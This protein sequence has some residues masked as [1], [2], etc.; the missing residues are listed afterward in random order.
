MRGACNTGSSRGF[1]G[2]PRGSSKLKKSR[3]EVRIRLSTAAWPRSSVKS[4]VPTDLRSESMNA[5][6]QHT[7]PSKRALMIM[8]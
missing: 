2:T 7:K 8:S 1:F 6:G 5:N 3:A 4:S